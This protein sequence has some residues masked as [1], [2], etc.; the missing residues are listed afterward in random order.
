ME[1]IARLFAEV[2]ADNSKFKRT[3]N[4]T[5]SMLKN[6]AGR[7][8]SFTTGITQGFGQAFGQ[9]AI[10][11][12]QNVGRAFSGVISGAASTEQQVADIKSILQA[13]D[14]E[15]SSIKQLLNDLA[16]N[17]NL[18]VSLKDAG[19]LTE[20]LARNGVEAKDIIDGMAESTILLSNATK[21]DYAQSADIL[22]DVMALWKDMGLTA[23]EAINS[24]TS[25]TNKSKLNLNEY[26]YAFANIAGAASN[27]KIP[28][29]DVNAAFI[30]TAS[31][32]KSGRTQGSSFNSFLTNLVPKSDNAVKAFKEL[33][34]ISIDLDKAGEKFGGNITSGFDAI[35]KAREIALEEGLEEDSEAMR[36]RI[37]SL[38][39]GIWD[40]NLFDTSGNLKDFE[41]LA[42]ILDKALSGLTDEESIALISKAFDSN[43]SEFLLGI[44]KTGSEGFKA[45][46]EEAS[47][48]SAAANAAIVTDTTLSRWET[49]KDTLVGIGNLIGDKF[50]PD[51][52]RLIE[53]ILNLTNLNRTDFVGAFDGLQQSFKRFVDF[54]LSNQ[55]SI[56]KGINNFISW[57]TNAINSIPDIIQ[58]L[59]YARQ[60]FISF[61]SALLSVVSPAI[62]KFKEIIGNL[63]QGVTFT[64]F[65]ALF[66]TIFSTGLLSDSSLN[67]LK[68][69][70]YSIITII[71]NGFS[72]ALESIL[73]PAFYK[74]TDWLSSPETH[75][76][77]YDILMKSWDFFTKWSLT[78]WEYLKPNLEN[79]FKYITSWITDAEKRNKLLGLL[80]SG[81]TFFIEW[82]GTIWDY[83]STK[84]GLFWKSLT[85]WISDS[86]KRTELLNYLKSYWVSFEQW[87]LDIWSKV[88]PRLEELYRNL[89]TWI[90][91]KTNGFATKFLSWKDSFISWLLLVKDEWNRIFP[92][93][94]RITEENFAPIVSNITT[95][96]SKFNELLDYPRNRGPQS[97]RDWGNMMVAIYNIVGVTLN[98]VTT[99]LSALMT[100]LNLLQDSMQALARGDFGAL[101]VIS[102]DF[103][104]LMKTLKDTPIEDIARWMDPLY[105][106]GLRPES[107]EV[108]ASS[109]SPE[110]SV[111]HSG[112]IIVKLDGDGSMMSRENIDF[113]AS[114]LQ[115][116]LNLEG[117]RVTS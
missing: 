30:A 85:S 18:K 47:K 98:A 69:L 102:N 59:E 43:A 100:A 91:S 113:L 8:S 24:I 22:T 104:E 55:N 110:T 116:R 5:N 83:V 74:L 90:D 39:S 27:L 3:M 25:V 63:L 36:K 7:F 54:L 73:K 34:L 56:A 72:M 11:S 105:W 78:V 23:T 31:F 16:V 89:I 21:G 95:M 48:V 67:Q 71:E 57:I 17:P 107:N 94:K 40:N 64:N 35:Q 111:N 15:A 52:K 79:L 2:S 50:L 99:S 87:A 76:K 115:Q 114:Q 62:A 29:Q 81:W 45:I 49:F 19:S 106:L 12:I 82:G 51:L 20:M 38:M 4:S 103:N 96:I 88:S 66:D 65:Q 10:R 75:Q 1:K 6:T 60:K 70:G 46:K 58:W 117:V 92:E 44:A 109:F 32:F 84:L 41:S 86:N 53:G 14:E 28:L 68:H 26:Q 33:G 42:G 77:A 108:G 9:Q 61:S 97:I 101:S 112:S 13:T 93:L 80:K 37:N